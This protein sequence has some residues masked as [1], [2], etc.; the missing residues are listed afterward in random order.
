MIIIFLYW[1][2]QNRKENDFFYVISK[3][4]KVKKRQK[5]REKSKERRAK[6]EEAELVTR[7]PKLVTLLKNV[8]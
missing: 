1:I 5:G 2:A 6:S 7:N 4:S 8:K 3:L